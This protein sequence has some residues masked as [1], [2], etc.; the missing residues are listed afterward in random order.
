MNLTRTATYWTLAA[1]ATLMIGISSAFAQESRHICEELARQSHTEAE[2]Q[3]CIEEF[4]EPESFRQAREDRRRQDAAAAQTA[5]E[6]ARYYDKTFTAAELKRFGAPYVAKR[7]FYDVYGRVYKSKT[8]TDAKHLCKYLGFEKNLNE[9]SISAPM[10]DFEN[11][12]F[13][14]VTVND[15]MFGSLDA[16]QFRFDETDDPSNIQVYT[17]LTCRRDRKEGDPESGVVAQTEAINRDVN[18]SRTSDQ[19]V[20]EDNSSRRLRNYSIDSNSPFLY[21]P[22]AGSG[23]SSQR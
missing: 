9:G 17:S 11:R 6:R 5:E 8:L 12:G 19:E 14:G 13:L 3:R 22:N 20:R 15:P 4:G 18:E 1:S 10:E 7:N 16:K 23:E 2:M 21:N